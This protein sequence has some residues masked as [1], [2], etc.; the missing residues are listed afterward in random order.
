MLKQ[1]VEVRDFPINFQTVFKNFKIKTN[2]GRYKVFILSKYYSQK[3]FP[4]EIL[5]RDERFLREKIYEFKNGDKEVVKSFAEVISKLL[6]KE[7]IDP[8]SIFCVIPASTKS[9]TRKRYKKFSKIVSRNLNY[10]N[11]FSCIKNVKDR[12]AKHISGK[13]EDILEYLKFNPK[14]IQGKTVI[15]FD[16]IITTGNS[17]LKIANTL[18]AYGAHD[19][20]GVFLAQTVR[21]VPQ[22][23]EKHFFN[24]LFYPKF[25]EEV[26]NDLELSFFKEFSK[27]T[28]NDFGLTSENDTPLIL[29]SKVYNNI[30][31][32]GIPTYSSIFFE[33]KMKSFPLNASIKTRYLTELKNSIVSPHNIF[34]KSILSSWLHKTLVSVIVD[35]ILTQKEKWKIAVIENDALFSKI[36]MEDFYIYMKNISKLFNFSFPEINLTIFREDSN[37]NFEKSEFINVTYKNISELKNEDNF[38]LIVDAGINKKRQKY[39]LKDRS[40]L[41]IILPLDY[42]V[43]KNNQQFYD[44]EL[45]KYEINEEKEDALKFILKNVFRKEKFRE[46]QMDIIKRILGLKST[47]GLLP[48]G[49]GKS[50]TYQLSALLQPGVVVII[51]PIKSLMEDQVSKLQDLGIGSSV[52]I[53]GNQDQNQKQAILKKLQ[54]GKYKLLFISPERLQ[55]K[56]F[57][58]L[59]KEMNL[60]ISFLVIDEAHCVSEWGQDFRPAYL[61]IA[62]NLK[63]IAVNGI[64]PIIALTGTASYSVLMD[65]K[66]IL[67]IKEENSILTPK[68]FDREELHFEVIKAKNKEKALENILFDKLPKIFNIKNITEISGIIFS[69]TIDAKNGLYSVYEFLKKKGFNTE[70]YSGRK[71]KKFKVKDFSF[72]KQK[73]QEKFL[74]N[75]VSILVATKAFGMGIDKPDIRY[76]IHYNLPSSIESF[77]QEAGRAGRDRKD[78]FSFLIFT[79]ECPDLTDIIL[80]PELPNNIAIKIFEN[81]DYINDDVFTQLKFHFNSFKGKEI[82][83]IETLKFY[84]RIRPHIS[85]LKKGEYKFLEIKSSRNSF[86]KIIY[87]LSILGIIDYYTVEF[88]GKEKIFEIKISKKDRKEIADN[89][90]NYLFKNGEV[91]EIK[92]K[93]GIEESISILI[94]FIYERLEKQRRKSLFN[95]VELARKAK[96]NDE[97]KKYILN[98]FN[99]SVY[100]RKLIEIIQKF[101]KI[102]LLKLIDELENETDERE[103]EILNVNLERLFESYPGN[104]YIHLIKAFLEIRK[105]KLKNAIN[106]FRKFS[107]FAPTYFV[108]KAVKKFVDFSKNLGVEINERDLE[109]PTFKK[110]K[111]IF[112]SKLD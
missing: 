85:K 40:K 49:S 64:T 105:R 2:I 87:R 110:S 9:K 53:N 26:L 83:K 54:E 30:L 4:D 7:I 103:F 21:Y 77:Y 94:D 73:V 46:G 60:K 1:E 108:K 27:F 36:A 95:I 68:T 59:L 80:N 23:Y 35:G 19:V 43:V 48:T 15:L 86:E 18:L 31:Q 99:E 109:V 91:K 66:R 32:R 33:D 98:Y 78:S 11:G 17:F 76:T 82:E 57:R 37:F 75:D 42:A 38:D 28:I 90:K 41:V 111:V 14:K 71:P 25:F 72:Y 97:V 107:E 65:I 79:E 112:Q 3:D 62:G 45:Q 96:T 29:A 56:S 10:K 34:A 106:N 13:N 44:F 6:K 22:E 92:N 39:Y 50:L 63:Q 100:V 74:S 52:F 70:I 12:P 47:I 84:R 89:L 104:P 67:Q 61:N 20:I 88:I 58:K 102:E 5:E 16:D 81:Y 69:S 101:N 93:L 24:C 8:D 51:D 55:I